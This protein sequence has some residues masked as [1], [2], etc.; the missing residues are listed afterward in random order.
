MSVDVRALIAELAQGQHGVVGAAQLKAARVERQPVRTLIARGDLTRIHPGVLAVAGAPD[1]WER[2]L[3]AGLLTLGPLALVSGEAA[4]ALHRLDRCRS[5]AVEFLLP[6]QVRNRRRA[7][8]VHSTST[9]V[10]TDR[11]SVSGLRCT[12]VTRTLVDLAGAG[13][14][15]R[16]LEA[17]V[18]SAV[19]AGTTTASV[20]EQRALMFAAK[21]RRRTAILEL[22]PDTGGHSPLERDFLTLVRR[23][24]LPRPATQAVHRVGTRTAARVD[25]LWES[26][27][28]VVE[29]SGR[30]GHASDAE[31][32]DD[33]RRR[34][35][36]QQIG[37]HV[38]E[39][40]R[41][42]V[43]REPDHVVAT[44]RCWLSP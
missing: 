41:I 10:P 2:R 23:A 4:A 27:D 20:L 40:T 43:E 16:R 22:L 28:L 19:R 38:I 29:V 7:L 44:L 6:R 15:R 14:E 1:T 21:D 35:E 25:F 5:E 30:V 13:I 17:A 34:N 36:L 24:G 8:T 32:A 26:S 42:Q 33:A 12:S 11:A 3:M 18:D 37:R 9:L 31:R 39:F